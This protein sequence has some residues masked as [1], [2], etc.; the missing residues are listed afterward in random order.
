MEDLQSAKELWKCNEIL[1][2][3]FMRNLGTLT[4]KQK[5]QIE[6]MIDNAF[7]TLQGDCSN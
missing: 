6:T 1:A 5:D 7:R 4:V 2:P 3:E